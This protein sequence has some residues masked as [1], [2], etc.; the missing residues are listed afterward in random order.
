MIV[1]VRTLADPRLYIF[2]HTVKSLGGKFENK[3]ENELVALPSDVTYTHRSYYGLPVLI[4]FV[5]RE[6]FH[7]G[8]LRR[9]FHK[10]RIREVITI[11][12]QHDLSISLVLY[13]WGEGGVGSN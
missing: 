12:A 6:K 8:A 5:R 1:I 7:E 9:S 11:H 13:T 2:Y 3:N 4:E 10:H